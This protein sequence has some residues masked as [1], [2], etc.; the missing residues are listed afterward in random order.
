MTASWRMTASPD[1]ARVAACSLRPVPRHATGCATP[2]VAMPRHT[3]SRR[4][5]RGRMRM[6]AAPHLAL[7]LTLMRALKAVLTRQGRDLRPL[8]LGHG[9]PAQVRHLRLLRSTPQSSAPP[10]HR[11]PIRR[12]HPP[13]AP[14]R[15]LPTTTLT[16]T[17]SLMHRHPPPEHAAW[18]SLL[19][20]DFEL[21]GSP[22]LS[23]LGRVHCRAQMQT[24]DVMAGLCRTHDI[25]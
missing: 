21:F 2:Q 9:T 7:L 8:A 22:L 23:P 6:Q 11:R 18:P 12:Q 5:V 24:T 20:L 16:P 4:C 3:S 25:K 15:L 1:A 13:P 17:A 10:R 14:R 19:S